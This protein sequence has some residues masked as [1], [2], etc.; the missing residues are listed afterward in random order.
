MFLHRNNHKYTWTS[1]DGK[2]HNHIDHIDRR[3][4]SSVI[5]IRCF[6]GADCETG[7][8][9]VKFREI[10]AVS[11]QAAQKCDGKRFNLRKL[12]ELEVREQYQIEFKNSSA[13]L[14]NLSDGKAWENIKENTKISAKESLGLYE[15]Q[16]HK[17]W[18]DEE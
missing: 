8:V 14:E 4:H 9:A 1:P 11:K 5:D 15:L 10:M 2:T 17:P 13:A 7:L 3:W 16:Q 6:V 18:L 12:N